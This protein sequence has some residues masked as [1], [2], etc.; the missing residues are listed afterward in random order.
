MAALAQTGRDKLCLVASPSL[1][2]LGGWLEQ[3]IAESTGKHGRGIVAIGDEQPGPPEVYGD[4]R[5]FCYVRVASE[6][7]EQEQAAQ[8]RA[9]DALADAGH[10]IVRLHVATP[11]DLAAEFFRW[12]LATAVAGAVLSLN[13]F[14]Q[15]DVEAAKVAA[16]SLMQTFDDQGALPPRQPVLEAD[17][18]RFFSDSGIAQRASAPS[19]TAPSASA[20]LASAPLATAPLASAASAR[21]LVAAHLERLSPGDYFAVNA[22]LAS[23]ARNETELQGLRHAVRDRR[24]VATSLGYGP[25]FLHSTGQLHKGGPNSGVFLQITARDS[26]DLSIPGQRYSFGVLADAQAQGDFEVLV[27]RDR[28]VLWVELDESEHAV[29]RLRELVES[30]L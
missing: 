4:D 12:E 21:A 8:D 30:A 20:P 27:K 16:R 18:M 29:S 22:Y 26:Q 11:N 24:R 13:P 9:M 19:A 7:A 1:A 25:R 6:P 3:L 14:T 28:R 15:P 5:L 17:G 10:P 23:H 2:S